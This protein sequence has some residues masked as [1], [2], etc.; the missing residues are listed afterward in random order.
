MEI[1]KDIKGYEGLYKVSNL[2]NVK[3]LER[4][5]VNGGILKEKNLKSGKTSSGYLNVSLSKN[6]SIKNFLVHQ[7]VAISFLNHKPNG[8][9]I[10]VDHINEDK[11]DNNVLNLRLLPHR[12]NTARGYKNK[13]SKHIGVSWDRKQLKWKVQIQ[14]KGSNLYLGSFDCEL[15]A[16]KKYQEKLKELSENNYISK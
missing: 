5:R 4:P 16:A 2:G 10:V 7:L 14:H 11:M 13:S 12:N 15:L 3:S 6:G 9:S 1:W 8:H